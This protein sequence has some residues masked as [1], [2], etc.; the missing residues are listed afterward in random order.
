MCLPEEVGLDASNV[1][2]LIMDHTQIAAACLVSEGYLRWTILFRTIYFLT[3][4]S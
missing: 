3:R 2:Q 4:K 1:W